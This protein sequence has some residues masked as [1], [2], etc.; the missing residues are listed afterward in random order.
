MKIVTVI[1]SRMGSRR[2]PGKAMIKIGKKPALQQVLDRLRPSKYIKEIYLATT[3]N[4]KDDALEH[5]AI[6]NN[7]KCFRGS[8]TDVLNSYYQIVNK[9]KSDGIV[10]ITGDCPLIDCQIVDQV[11][12][13]FIEGDFDCVTNA[14]PATYPD[15]LDV[16]IF[17]RLAINK[18]WREAKSDF[19]HE[20]I[21]V[22]IY[23]HPKL[24]KIKAVNSKKDLSKYRWTLDTLDDLRLLKLIFGECEKSKIY[25]H[26]EDIL[27]ILKKHPNWKKI[28]SDYQRNQG[29]RISPKK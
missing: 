26:M 2:L 3:K 24:F 9:T 8:E 29:Y 4:P 25:C 17:S 27:K 6:K 12:K 22:Y 1:Q 19:E 7:I 15:G 5:W 23:E 20:H 28:N 16:E 21:N 11:L 14:H 13:T 18:T 10:R